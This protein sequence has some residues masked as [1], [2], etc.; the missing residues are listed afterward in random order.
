MGGHCINGERTLVPKPGVGV[1]GRRGIDV[2]ALGVGDNEQT[3][4]RR[5][6]EEA[7]ERF[8]ASGTVALEE[9]DLW[10]DHADASSEG[11]DACPTER[12]QTLHVVGHSP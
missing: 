3:G 2:T 8:E 7:L 9:R 1:G 10:L 11:I 6:L 4:S 5:I 12:A